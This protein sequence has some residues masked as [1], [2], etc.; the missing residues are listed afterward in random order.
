MEQWAK[1]SS[2]RWV[3]CMEMT[4]VGPLRTQVLGTLSSQVGGGWGM[5]GTPDW[6]HLGQGGAVVGRAWLGELHLDPGPAGRAWFW[7]EGVFGS[8][9]LVAE[10]NA[11]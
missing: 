8:Q 4:G 5:P 6:A 11:S 3:L 2:R 10:R 9:Y 1:V 7:G